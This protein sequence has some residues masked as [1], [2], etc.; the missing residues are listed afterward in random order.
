MLLAATPPAPV[1]TPPAY[2]A[3]P[4]PSSNTVRAWTEGLKP[5]SPFPSADQLAPSHFAMLLAATPPALVKLP[6]A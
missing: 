4:P 2:S 1:K 3:G 5:E 6:P